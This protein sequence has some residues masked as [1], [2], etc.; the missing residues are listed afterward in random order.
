[1]QNPHPVGSEIAEDA[2]VSKVSPV[3]V[4]VEAKQEGP[5]EGNEAPNTREVV[6]VGVCEACRTEESNCD[7]QE[8]LAL[9]P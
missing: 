2:N 7:F 9:D 8:D 6:A 4:G 5:L 3:A 1:M